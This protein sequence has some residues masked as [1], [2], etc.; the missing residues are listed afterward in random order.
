MSITSTKLAEMYCLLKLLN[1]LRERMKVV[2]TFF[3][4]HFRLGCSFSE[5]QS[6]FF[7]SIPLNWQE[8][9]TSQSDQDTVF[10][11]RNRGNRTSAFNEKIVKSFKYSGEKK[12]RFERREV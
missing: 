12:K 1:C 10:N 4:A 7:I 2:S 6:F 3:C 5:F 11:E 8:I 9:K